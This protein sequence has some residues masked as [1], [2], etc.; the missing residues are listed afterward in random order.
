MVMGDIVIDFSHQTQSR[1]S[2]SDVKTP[3]KPQNADAL[4][5]RAHGLSGVKRTEESEQRHIA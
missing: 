2:A 4:W 1:R 5:N 3:L